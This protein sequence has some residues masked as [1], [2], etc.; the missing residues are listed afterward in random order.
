MTRAVLVD[1]CVWIDFLRGSDTPHRVGLRQLLEAHRVLLCGVI[2]AE[3]IQGLRRRTQADV[4]HHALG[5][6]PYLEMTKQVWTRAG[7]LGARLSGSGLPV[8][9]SDLTI[10]ALTVETEV[11]L[12]SFDPHFDRLPELVRYGRA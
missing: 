2:L 4:L 10:A 3:L 5:G 1:T 12:Y 6:L 11:A 8:P 7:Q 9:L